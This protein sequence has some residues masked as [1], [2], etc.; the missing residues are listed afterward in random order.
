M[1]IKTPTNFYF[2]RH[3]ESEHNVDPSLPD[4][5]DVTLTERGRMQAQSIQPIIQSLPIK[6][7]CVSPL[8]RALETKEIIAQNLS[9]QIVVIE[10][11]RECDGPVWTTMTESNGITVCQNV[12]HFM[13]RTIEGINR[14]LQYPGPVLIVAHGGVHWAMCH[15]MA[16][17]EYEKK[18]DNCVP[19]HFYQTEDFQWQGRYLN[20]KT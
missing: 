18:I 6:T 17:N 19:A 7:I 16:V 4:Q 11:L 20:L 8:R 12:Q 9:C 10:E 3:G 1:M 5:L 15:T 2:V 14:S 13:K